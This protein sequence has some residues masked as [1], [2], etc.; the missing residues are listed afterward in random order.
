MPFFQ[1]L[2]RNVLVLILAMA[3]FAMAFILMVS[4]AVALGIMYIVAR[5][6]GRPFA[7]MA[8]WQSR[9]S[10]M[11][12]QFMRTG[13]AASQGASEHGAG[14]AHAPASNRTLR[15]PRDLNVTDVE[16]RDIS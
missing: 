13:P 7:P 15:R 9:R 6:R 10:G 16:A 5:V 1:N 11:Q 4:T 3:G 14:A 8:F 2:L 12:W